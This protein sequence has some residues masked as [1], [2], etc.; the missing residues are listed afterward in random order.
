M[1]SL[2]CLNG[3]VHIVGTQ[4]MLNKVPTI[5]EKWYLEEE[6]KENKWWSSAFRP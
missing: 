6:K 3:D 2:F 4:N 1:R 5:F